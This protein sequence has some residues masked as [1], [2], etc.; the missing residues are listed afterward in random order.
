V[1][2]FKSPIPVI[3]LP[4]VAFN[5]K[6]ELRSTIETWLR[7][8][9]VFSSDFL[10][11]HFI[12]KPDNDPDALAAERIA[13]TS[14]TFELKYSQGAWKPRQE[15]N[16]SH[17]EDLPAGP[18]L[19]AGNHVHQAWRQYPDTLDSFVCGIVPD[20]VHEYKFHTLNSS[21][22]IHKAIAV[23]SRLYPTISPQRPL[24]GKRITIKDNFKIDGIKTTQTNRAWTELFGPETVSAALVKQLVDQGA[25][26]VGKTKMCSFASSEEATDGWI[27]FHAPFNP[28]ADGCQSSSG[29]TTGGATS[30][31][32]Y[33][34][35]DF[36][37][38]TDTT[39]S[40]RWPAAW[41]GL[42]GLRAAHGAAD[43]KDVYRSCREFDALGLLGRDLRTLE[44]VAAANLKATHGAMSRPTRILFSE[45]FLPKADQ[46]R[47]AMVKAFIRVLENA[48]NVKHEPIEIAKLW[49]SSPP[50]G[51]QGKSLPEYIETTAFNL[52]YFDGYHDPEFVNFRQKYQEK[53]DKPPYV[54]P[55]MRWKW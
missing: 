7:K 23:P 38:G 44:T 28:R 27:D 39:G 29:S 50:K 17:I 45:D 15:L 37:I 55:Y 49:E 21:I 40:I 30:L 1:A 46:K 6:D 54:G 31:A 12:V 48:L 19:I 24:H 18:Y 20:S 34:W 11:A 36:S 47:Q 22:G 5:S 35:I 9:D 2:S 10:D 3:V 4:A 8:D 32:G 25:I 13:V 42:F 26:I 33:D 16:C 43:M 52:F 14:G 53:F 41:H 51:S